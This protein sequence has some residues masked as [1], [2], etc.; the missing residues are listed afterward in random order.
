VPL[1]GR[2]GE[3]RHPVDYQVERRGWPMGDPLEIAGPTWSLL[4][5]ISTLS[6]GQDLSHVGI[7]E[8]PQALAERL[9]KELLFR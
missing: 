3:G 6:I 1:I 2:P 4:H 8:D 9:L 5:G 7:R